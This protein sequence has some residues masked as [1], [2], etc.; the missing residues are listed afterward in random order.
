MRTPRTLLPTLALIGLAAAPARADVTP[1]D[2][3]LFNGKNMTGW[4]LVTPQNAPIDSVCHATPDGAMA[5]A[6]KPI[7]YLLSDADYPNY[8]LHVEWRWPADAAKNSNSGILVDLK[9]GPVDRDTWPVSIQ[10]QTKTGRAGDLLPMAG[11]TF[12]EPLSTPPGA[13]IPQK[14]RLAAGNEKP[15]GEWN[16]CDV[17][18]KDGTL[19]VTVNGVLQNK[20]SG[21]KPGSGRVG[22]Q[23][24]GF[25]YELRNLRLEP[26]P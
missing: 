4:T 25:P 24:E 8:R 11:A 5:V 7:G 20:V 19:E 10:V 1:P 21:C 13:P 15:L 23:L 18:C 22:I 3:S 17:V 6:G 14:S 26:L 9:G 16:S 12:A 2:L